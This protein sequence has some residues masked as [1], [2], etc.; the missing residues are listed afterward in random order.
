MHTTQT[1]ILSDGVHQN[2]LPTVKLLCHPKSE[3]TFYKHKSKTLLNQV[4]SNIPVYQYSVFNNNLSRHLEK[5]SNRTSIQSYFP[6][7]FSHHPALHGTRNPK[8]INIFVFISYLLSICPV[9]FWTH[10]MFSVCATTSVVRCLKIPV[11]VICLSTVYFI[12]CSLALVL[13]HYCSQLDSSQA[14]HAFT[15]LYSI[16]PHIRAWLYTESTTSPNHSQL[17]CEVTCYYHH[18]SCWLQSQLGLPWSS[19]NFHYQI[20]CLSKYLSQTGTPLKEKRLIHISI[21]YIPR[22]I[23]IGARDLYICCLSVLRTVQAG[24]WSILPLGDP[25]LSSLQR[26]RRHVLIHCNSPGQEY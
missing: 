23:K 22:S 19:L 17:R 11:S 24:T 3:C 9:A 7:M 15:D 20:I 25:Y 2:M 18:P 14:I 5:V 4:P 13:V 10:N 1:A 6:S 12:C 21:N 8:Q 16:C 26:N